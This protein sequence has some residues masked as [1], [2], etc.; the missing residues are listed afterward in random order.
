M[1]HLHFHGQRTPVQENRCDRVEEK[2]L[3]AWL[4]VGVNP[5]IS[6]LDDAADGFLLARCK[7]K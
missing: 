1:F 4:F 3:Y 7:D 6:R 5:N 2:H